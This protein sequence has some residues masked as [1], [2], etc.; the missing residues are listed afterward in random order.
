MIDIRRD[1]S[2]IKRRLVFTK[3][4]DC[5]L[6][7]VLIGLCIGGF[8]LVFGLGIIYS[9]IIGGLYLVFG[10]VKATKKASLREIEKKIPDLEWQLRTAADNV[11]RKNEIIE[12]LNLEV[13]E[14]IGFVNF[15]DL[16]SG[17]KTLVRMFG[18]VFLGVLIFY[19]QNTGFNVIEAV[20][21][22]EGEGIFGGITGLFFDEN[23]E[24]SGEGDEDDFYGEESDIEKGRRELELELRSEENEVDLENEGD[25]EYGKKGGRRFSGQVSGEQ[26]SSYSE[27]I[28]VDEEELVK[29]YMDEI[30]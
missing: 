6:N 16:L 15:Y 26:D 9:A 27:D 11:G 1:I 24:S 29:K 12:K 7:S 4:L 14:K 19:V 2:R 23:L 8:L 17:K 20:T 21:P 10:F 3:F 13:A 22:E 28:S 25:L 5:F 30:Y 18:I